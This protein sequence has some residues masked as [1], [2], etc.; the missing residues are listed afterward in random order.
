[1]FEAAKRLLWG[2]ESRRTGPS[3]PDP[4]AR[5]LIEGRLGSA[6]AAVQVAPPTP[7]PAAVETR[8]AERF[9][10]LTTMTYLTIAGGKRVD[11]RII[12]LSRMA[13]AVEAKFI[14]VDPAAVIKVGAQPVKQGR[15]IRLGMVFRFEKPLDSGLCGPNI[16]L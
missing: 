15:P 16:I 9:V 4:G 11:A 10:P 7:E 6:R 5:T 8:S 14:Q 3:E 2:S 1:M 12:N 13:V